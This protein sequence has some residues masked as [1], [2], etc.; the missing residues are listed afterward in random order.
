[1][2]LT[3]SWVLL[4]VVLLGGGIALYADRLGRNL[5]K[6]RLKLG[7]LRPRKT[8]EIIVFAAGMLTPLIAILAI[9]A[10][11]AEARLWIIRGYKAVQDARKA[12]GEKE[13]AFK[14]LERTQS[15]IR[16]LRYEL[17]D[18]QKSL[19][20]LRKSSGVYV[21]Q[22]KSAQQR[23]VQATSKANTLGRSVGILTKEVTQ[24]QAALNRVQGDLADASRTLKSVSQAYDSLQEKTDEANDQ[25]LKLDGEID[26]LKQ[27]IASGQGDLA[28]LRSELSA[29]QKELK[30][31]EEAQKIARE[32]FQ[33]E[34]DQIGTDLN[35]AKQALIL[36]RNQMQFL[37]EK[38][39]TEPLI[40]HSGQ[41][42]IRLP[43]QRQMNLV[44]AERAIESVLRY[45]RLAARD[46]GA[47]PGSDGHEAGLLEYTENG[48]RVTPDQQASRLA[49]DLVG[50]PN[51]RIIVVRAL[52]NSFGRQ[53]V[54]ITI[55]VY[56]NPVVFQEGELLGEGRIDN[57]L[58]VGRMIETIGEILRDQVRRKAEERRM[59]PV[60]GRD[61]AYGSVSPDDIYA[62]VTQ[63]QNYG[64]PVRLQVLAKQATRAGGPLTLEFRLR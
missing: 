18:Q 12:V 63:I 39:L 45:A 60:T 27:Q 2:D 52:F 64:R 46:Q 19:D 23:A 24:R 7:S 26:A 28:R 13:N 22:A 56:P 41:E 6:K 54:P 21:E 10:V 57:N 59:I 43:V 33:R 17:E 58:A 5:G 49:K 9:M 61:D 55:D 3:S 62:V 44:E 16:D 15:R 4:L 48:V 8:A 31:A 51:E 42:L 34:L 40:F 53:F 37:T 36:T 35:D 1:M 30:E 47:E 38:S 32:Q 25:V 11:S 20:R 14:E 50:A 29:K